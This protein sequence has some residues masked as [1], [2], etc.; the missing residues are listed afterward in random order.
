MEKIK[1]ICPICGDRFIP[2][3]EYTNKKTGYSRKQKYCSKECWNKRNPKS[4]KIC[5]VCNNSFDT[6]IRE[7]IYCS[8]E[9][10]NI[11]MRGKKLSQETKDKM[12]K[13]KQGYMPVNIFLSGDKHPFWLKDRSKVAFIETPEYNKFRKRINGNYENL[14]TTAV[15]NIPIPKVMDEYLVENITEI[16]K[17]LNSGLIEFEGET[18]E[19]LNDLVYDLYELNILE[20]NRIKDYFRKDEFVN[21]DNWARY[22]KTLNET[23]EMFFQDK[24]NI[25]YYSG[26]DIGFG[27]IITALYFSNSDNY[28]PSSKKTLRY[29]INEIISDT[30]ENFIAMREIVWGKNCIYIIRDNHLHNWSVTKAFED[31]QKI[32]NKLMK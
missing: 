18:K 7:K 10:R 31:G 30:E 16:S 2:F 25:E 8:L 17:K 13:A 9:C 22:K 27:L 4:T 21:E 23:L 3:G 19:K 24:I 1:R 6:Y 26:A 28:Q 20:I 14:D 5:P 29:I 12:S 11:G 32:L 15:K